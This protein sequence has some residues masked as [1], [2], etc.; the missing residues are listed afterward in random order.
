[1]K[2]N[3]VDFKNK[4]I[5]DYRRRV[6]YKN[7]NRENLILKVIER[8]QKGDDYSCFSRKRKKFF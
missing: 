2:Y 1:M 6:S 4:Q 5:Q 3:N 7:S 8:I